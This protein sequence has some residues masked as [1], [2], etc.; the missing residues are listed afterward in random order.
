MTRIAAI[1]PSLH[2]THLAALETALRSQTRPPDAIIV[3]RGVSPNGRARNLGVAQTDAEWLLFFDDDAMPGHPDL[4]EQLLASATKPG[5]GAVGSARVLPLDAPPFQHHVAAQ[6][7]RIIHPVVPHDTITN[8]D[9]PH[10][11]CTITTTCLLIHRS[12]FTRAGGFNDTLIRGVDTEFLVRLRRLHTP[13]QPVNIVQ[14][15]Q[16]WVYHPAPDTLGH[17][18]QKHLNY[19]MGHAQEVRLDRHRARGGNWFSTPIHAAVWLLWRTII[20]PFHCV[21][22]YSYADPRWQLR[23]APLKAIASYASALGYVYGWYTHEKR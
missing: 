22:P 2:G 4:I 9:S 16:T 12:W 15:G 19:G 5:I 11:Y 8:P 14:A 20:I 6:V 21:L 17:L 13:E 7:A 3:I 1:I 18:W 23:W 10:F